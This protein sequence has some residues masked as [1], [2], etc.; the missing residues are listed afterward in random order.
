MFTLIQEA[1]IVLVS[2]R[3]WGMSYS[4]T[5]VMLSQMYASLNLPPI[6]ETLL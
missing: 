5:T 2:V 4:E 6:N 3:L 1:T